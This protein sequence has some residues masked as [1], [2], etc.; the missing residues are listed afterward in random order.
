MAE[1]FIHVD[2]IHFGKD[3]AEVSPPI[4]DELLRAHL[5]GISQIHRQ[6]VRVALAHRLPETKRHDEAVVIPTL[7][8]EIVNASLEVILPSH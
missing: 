3:G 1:A 7:L 4:E 2:V 6:H 5:G 8:V